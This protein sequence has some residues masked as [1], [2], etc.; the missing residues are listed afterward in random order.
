MTPSPALC[1]LDLAERA[2]QAAPG[3]LGVR[4]AAVIARQS[5][6]YAMEDFWMLR[7]RGVNSASARV[8]LLCLRE[9]LSD[10]ELARDV[11]YA[12]HALS[13][14]CHHHPC[15]LAP[16]EAELRPLLETARGFAVEIERQTAGSQ[17]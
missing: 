4:A 1:N 11:A 7:E 17:R 9:Y 8:R 16:A 10:K 12:F 2:L 6:E 15:R 14:L 5:I 13:R 3:E